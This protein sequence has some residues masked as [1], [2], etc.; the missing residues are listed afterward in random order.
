MAADAKGAPAPVAA[1]AEAADANGDENWREVLDK[2]TGRK[3]FYHRKTK[4]TTWVVSGCA[5]ARGCGRAGA[6]RA[7]GCACLAN[8]CVQDPRKH[9]PAGDAGAR[10]PGPES[11]AP[12]R[13]SIVISLAQPLGPHATGA[14]PLPQS[15]ST[16]SSQ[17]GSG[18]GGLSVPVCRRRPLRA[19]RTARRRAT[20]GEYRLTSRRTAR[21]ARWQTR[22]GCG[23][24][25]PRSALPASSARA[26]PALT[27]AAQVDSTDVST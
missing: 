18:G 14:A 5:A 11:P 16:T 2:N 22:T 12:S 19:S 4:Q 6:R 7:F 10:P 20:R 1:R 8:Y 9:P 15:L 25:R 13:S 21:T 24:R 27:R 17:S 23:P 26:L 3:Y